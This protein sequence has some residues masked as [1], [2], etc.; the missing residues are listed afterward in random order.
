MKKKLYLIFVIFSLALSNA[1]AKSYI[2]E[3]SCK[4]TEA[5]NITTCR[6]HSLD[7][8]KTM[9][10]Q[11]IDKIIRQKIKVTEDGANNSYA[12]KDV[13]AITAGLIKSSIQEEKQD[14][15]NYY[16]KAKLDADSEW[17]LNTIKKFKQAQSNESS[18]YHETLTA[19]HQALTLAR[20]EA[21][22][23]K[24]QISNTSDKIERDRLITQ[25][26][27]KTNKIALSNMIE[28]GYHYY[29][30]GRHDAAAYWFR[31]AAEQGLTIGQSNLELMQHNCSGIKQDDVHAIQ[32]CRQSAEQGDAEGQL[33]LGFM[34]LNGHG[35]E[36]SNTIA[37]QWF[38][39][40]A[41][42]GYAPAQAA[43]GLLYY[44]GQLVK[45]DYLTAAYWFRKAAKQDNA[46]AQSSLGLMYRNGHGVKQDNDQ[47]I[48]WLNKSAEQGHVTAINALAWNYA[49]CNFGCDDDKAIH[50]ATKLLTTPGIAQKQAELDSIAAAYARAGKFDSA[51]KVQEKAIALLSNEKEIVGYKERLALYKNK[52]P[53]TDPRILKKMQDEEK[54]KEETE[55]L[56]DFMM[57]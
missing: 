42:Q 35:V 34:Y 49:S 44:K 55:Q 46:Q 29:H 48:H 43:L 38:N 23:L 25:Y 33:N 20:T 30:K 37:V 31:I 28:R 22:Q 7:Q 21:N 53:Y 17:I 32:Q 3:H 12:S 4:L 39:R 50:W 45:Q 47:A 2:R 51:I 5:D 54:K 8:A 57:D 10:T 18:L 15:K 56:Y 16:L 1:Q 36:Q 14:G 24:N 6:I 52:Q 26:K 13:D 11:E 41:E 19:N 27:E 9:L 40:S